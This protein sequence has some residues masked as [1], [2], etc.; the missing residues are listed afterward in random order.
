MKYKDLSDAGKSELNS[1]IDIADESH[2]NNSTTSS[3]WKYECYGVCKD[4]EHFVIVESEF[5][6]ILAK[7]GELGIQLSATQPITSC[8]RFYKRNQMSLWDMKNIALLINPNKN[9]IGFKGNEC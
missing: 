5:Q 9:E 8:T 6:T 1:V 2:V 4:C 7:C 3:T